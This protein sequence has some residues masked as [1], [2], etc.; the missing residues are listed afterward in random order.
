MKRA[1]KEGYAFAAGGSSALL[2]AASLKPLMR[3]M[4]FRRDVRFFR[5]IGGGIIEA[6]SLGEIAKS[7]GMCSSA[8][9][10]AASLKLPPGRR[11]HVQT[12]RSSALLG[13]AS[14]KRF[15]RCVPA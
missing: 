7:T 3:G 9:L 13:A 15:F 5:P 6:V 12:P 4:C 10:G 8:L 2:G 1:E 11:R 14:L